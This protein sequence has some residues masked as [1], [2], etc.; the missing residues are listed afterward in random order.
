MSKMLWIAVS[1]FAASFAFG[2]NA[3]KIDWQ[4]FSEPFVT[5]GRSLSIQIGTGLVRRVLSCIKIILRKPWF[6]VEEE[7][8]MKPMH[9]KLL[10]QMRWRRNA[11]L[12]RAILD[13]TEP[14]PRTVNP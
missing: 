13:L 3:Q 10:I 11:Q 6:F 5:R 7:I 8:K 2:A 4:I 12:G 14:F 1:F 9:I